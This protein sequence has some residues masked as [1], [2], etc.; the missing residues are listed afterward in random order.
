M[1]YLRRREN[2]MQISNHTAHGPPAA[3]SS[4]VSLVSMTFSLFWRIPSWKSLTHWQF[5]LLEFLPLEGLSAAPACVIA[6][7]VVGVLRPAPV[8]QRGVASDISCSI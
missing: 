5:S 7:S 1:K 2:H 6:A 8:Q 4:S 3:C